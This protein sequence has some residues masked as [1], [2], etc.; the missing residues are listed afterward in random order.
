MEAEQ[1]IAILKRQ[2]FNIENE[3]ELQQQIVSVL[4]KYQVA[5]KREHRLNEKDIPDFLIGDIAM[6]IKIKGRRIDIFKQCMRYSMHDEVKSV[7]LIT[8]VMIGK[9]PL[10]NDKPFYILNISSAWF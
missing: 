9:P 6:E 4:D 1:L 2:R 7:L 8:N 3:K 10:H 5:Y